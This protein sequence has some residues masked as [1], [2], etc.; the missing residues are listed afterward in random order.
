MRRRFFS[1]IP[2]PGAI[3]FTG[4]GGT[5][6]ALAA[7]DLQLEPYDPERVQGHILSLRRVQELCHMLEGMTKDQ[8][9]KLTGLEEKRADVI[10]FG[11][12]IMLEFMEAVG[13]TY[14]AVSDRDNQEGYLSLKLGLI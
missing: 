10:V 8:R 4:I 11:A 2:D 3:V 7:L 9:K 14:V 13:A 1:E 5:A 12:I 6:T